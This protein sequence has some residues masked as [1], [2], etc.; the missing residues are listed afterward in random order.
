MR[1][2]GAEDCVDVVEEE[3][4]D[5][6]CFSALAKIEMGSIVMRA[7]AG[8]AFAGC[9]LVVVAALMVFPEH[10]I[11]LRILEDEVEEP[12]LLRI[13]TGNEHEV[14]FHDADEPGISRYPLG[15]RPRPEYGV[16][17]RALSPFSDGAT[18]RWLGESRDHH[19]TPDGLFEDAQKSVVQNR[20][21]VFY[22]GSRG[23]M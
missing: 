22:L 1:S 10:G 14:T 23:S 11:A 9:G 3:T 12:L 6:V 2:V 15:Q 8:G 17:K 5:E 19:P 4:V 20:R 18:E 21:G 13:R 16:E 7:P